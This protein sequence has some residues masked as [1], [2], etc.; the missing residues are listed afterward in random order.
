MSTDREVWGDLVKCR[1]CSGSSVFLHR[2]DSMK[3][4]GD[5][6]SPGSLIDRLAGRA[7]Q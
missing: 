6:Y 5:R 4:S 2:I 1:G 7:N 3:Y